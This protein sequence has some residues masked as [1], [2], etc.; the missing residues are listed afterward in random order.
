MLHIKAN[1]YDD[2]EDDGQYGVKVGCFNAIIVSAVII[3]VTA[4]TEQQQMEEKSAKP[5]NTYRSLRLNLSLLLTVY[6]LIS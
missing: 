6:W 2:N 5:N 3:I 4:A 1:E